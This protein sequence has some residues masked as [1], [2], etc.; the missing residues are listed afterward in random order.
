VAWIVAYRPARSMPGVDFIDL[1]DVDERRLEV[2][3]SPFFSLL[4]ATRDA[5]GAERSRTPE[6]WCRAIRAHLTP[7][8]YDVLAPLA[9]AERA[10]VPDAI[11]PVP[12]P[13]QQSLQDGL[14]RVIAREE[15]LI[16]DIHVCQSA[17]RAGDWNEPA[18]DPRRWVR[19]FVVTLA[20]AW[21]GFE[22]VWQLAQ[23]SLAREAERVAAAAARGSHRHV[24]DTLLPDARV[25]DG[26]WEIEGFADEDVGYAIA[27]EGLV[28]IPLV[29]GERAT[30][31]FDSGMAISHVG[32][33][34]H[35]PEP[36]RRPPSR[37]LEALL[38]IPRARLLRE[39]GRPASNGGLAAKLQT[40]PS[41]VTHHV[42]ALE[43]AGLVARERSGRHVIV[44]RT[45]RGD[46]LL[47][48]Y[49]EE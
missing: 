35:P 18:R 21:N 22:P 37:S 39:L 29:A 36:A 2:A 23:D 7:R 8:D 13:P 43:A 9:T 14:E 4:M 32:Y 20:R 28:V 26:R 34:L 10:Y 6:A 41:A 30:M 33:P 48:L 17:G 27:D 42:T 3:V 47:A 45:R 44:S 46:A 38:G 12:Q 19:S 40:V 16:S 5:A 49:D 24:L 15:A 1:R 31:V 11:L 25:R